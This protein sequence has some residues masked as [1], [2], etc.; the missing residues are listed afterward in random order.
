MRHAKLHKLALILTFLAIAIPFLVNE[1]L[2][3]STVMDSKILRPLNHEFWYRKFV[4]GGLRKTRIDEFRIVTIA[5]GVEPGWALG[6][7]RCT[8]RFFMEKVLRKVADADPRV[9]VVDKWYGHIPEGVCAPGTDGTDALREAVQAIAVKVPI[10]MA[11][12]SYTRDEVLQFCKPGKSEELKPEEMVLGDYEPMGDGAPPGQVIL[13][14]ARIN[15]DIRK[16][17]LGWMAFRNCD[18]TGKPEPWPTLAT[19]AAK[20]LDPH[21]MQGNNLTKLQQRITHPYTKLVAEGTFKT[22]SAI[23]LLCKNASPN[24]D[25]E[26]CEPTDDKEARQEFRTRVVIIGE[27]W[28]DLHKLDDTVYT[29]PELQANYIAALLDQS[30]LQPVPKWATVTMSFFWL[31][32]IFWIFYFWRPELPELAL[33]VSAV[34]TFLLGYLFSAVITRQFG[35]FADVIPPTILEIIGLYLARRIEMLLDEHKKPGK[36]A[37]NV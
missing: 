22:V 1:F 10:V 16:I 11:L 5:R 34:L 28:R 18:V 37:H 19:A 2:G 32:F 26:H 30:I 20:S 15:G 17:P 8:H 31:G 13:G 4:P 33:A 23:H 3:E 35:I 24:V 9:I 12:G 21:I 7:N 29:G 36:A 14:L 6:E 25:W 27:I